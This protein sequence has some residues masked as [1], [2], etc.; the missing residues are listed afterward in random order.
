KP[1]QN[2][3][4]SDMVE[5]LPILQDGAHPWTSKMDEL[6]VG[7][8]FA[9]GDIKRLLANLLG[10]SAME[11]ILQRAGLIRYMGTAVNDSELFSANRTRVWRALK[12]T[13]P[14]NV[15]PDSVL[16]EPLGPE[17]NPRAYVSRAFQKW[18]NVT[19]N[20]PDLNQME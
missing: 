13:F 14:I 17:E 6:M 8:Q 1:W 5:K 3:D 10:V 4:M 15:H 9:M 19:G 11:E 2:T 7:T 12:D 18:R 16:I 20:D